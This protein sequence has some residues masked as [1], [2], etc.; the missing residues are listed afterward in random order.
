MRELDSIFGMEA[1]YVLDFSN[2]SMAAFF[3][4]DLNID[5]ESPAYV[6]NGGTSKAK[7]LRALLKAVNDAEAVR[8]LN[9]LWEYRAALVA[10]NG[11]Q[12]SIPNCEARFLA[13]LK[14]LGAGAPNVSAAVPHGRP[15]PAYDRAGEVALSQQLNELHALQPQPR[16]YAFEKFLQRLFAFY[17]L[18]PRESFRLTGEQI[19]GSFVLG[20]H[21][22]LLEAKWQNHFLDNGP[23]HILQ[24]KVSSKMA[25]TRGLLISYSGF[26][27]DAFAA[28][29]KGSSIICMSGL[30]IHDALT[31]HIPIDLVLTKKLRFASETGRIY[32]EVRELFP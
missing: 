8:I 14:R 26:S 31:R 13:V 10:R 17:G 15:V 1:G 9:S 12:E 3:A 7:R 28:F 27:S 5:I 32:A 4:E 16:G 24:G 2:P 23:L 30:D 21:T 20:D 25:W 19:D 29:G 6:V 18:Q 22:Y 11:G